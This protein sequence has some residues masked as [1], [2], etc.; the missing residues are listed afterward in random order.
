MKTFRLFIGLFALLLA[1]TIVSGCVAGE[2][3]GKGITWRTDDDL[4]SAIKKDLMKADQKYL[5]LN[6]QIKPGKTV[7]VNGTVGSNDEKALVEA[8]VRKVFG[9]NK[10]INNLKAP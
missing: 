1:A 9:V 4:M 6:V 3:F 7:E 10:V 5:L 8:I 2:I